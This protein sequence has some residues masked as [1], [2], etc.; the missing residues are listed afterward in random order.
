MCSPT[1]SF[2]GTS[3]P[4]FSHAGVN[5]SAN[6][7]YGVTASPVF[8]NIGGTYNPSANDYRVLTGQQI[9]ATLQG[10]PTGFTVTK[11]TWAIKPSATVF[12]TYN[13]MATSNQLVP[14][15]PTELTGPAVGSFSVAPLA[16][17]DS[18]AESVTVTCTVSVTAPD[19]KLL[20][21]TATAPSVTVE[22][23]TVTHWD[24]HTGYVQQLQGQSGQVGFGLKFAP[25]STL[26][27]GKA[28]Q[29]ATIVVPPPFATTGG[30]GCF[31]QLITPDVEISNPDPTQVP[32]DPKNKQ[33]GLDNSFPYK[34][35][36]WDVSGLGAN[37]DGPAVLFENYNTT[38]GSGYTQVITNQDFTTWLMYQPPGG[39][40]VPLQSYT[41]NWSFTSKWDGSHW[42]L[43][44]ASPS[45]TSGDPGYTGAD[46]PKFPQWKLVQNNTSAP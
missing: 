27:G 8:V 22:K 35:Y 23:P 13:E 38:S 42:N 19:G 14:L 46:T 37:F 21:L 33:Q 29:K 3:G 10:I 34:G 44:R 43:F 39:V 24:I 45:P 40:W 36:K 16:F 12:K 28:W 2:S 18:A 11:Y 4:G 26:S 32:T 17:Y 30:S 15:G 6:E 5:G 20:T 7:A 1:V 41:W 9:A 31:A 25:G